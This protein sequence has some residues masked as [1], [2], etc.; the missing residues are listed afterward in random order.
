MSTGLAMKGTMI[1]TDAAINPGTP[2]HL[3]FPFLPV[4]FP[5]PSPFLHLNPLSVPF[6]S[7]FLFPFPSPFPSPSPSLPIAFQFQTPFPFPFP[8]PSPTRCTGNSGG[9]LCNEWGEVIGINTMI[10]RRANSIGFA[11]PINRVKEVVGD[12]IE[13]KQVGGR[14]LSEM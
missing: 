11:V 3:A 14:A 6:L 12:L 5:Y 4:L 8:F 9:P 1:Q 13:G 2:L 7:T 10:R